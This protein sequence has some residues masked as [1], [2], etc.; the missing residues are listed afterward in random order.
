MK[1]LFLIF[2]LAGLTASLN[3]C[4]ESTQEKTKDAL[5]SIGEDIESNTKKAGEEIEKGAKKAQ[6]EVQEEIDGTDD[7]SGN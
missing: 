6:K 2:M 4:R 7:V 5:E 3:S 1:K